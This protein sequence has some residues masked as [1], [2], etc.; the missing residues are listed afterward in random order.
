MSEPS[1]PVENQREPAS[2]ELS[3]VIPCY[4]EEQVLRYTI[5]QLA[6]AFSGAG[7]ALEIVLVDNGSTDRTSVVIEELAMELPRIVPVRVQENIGYGNGILSGMSHATAKWVGMIP[8]DGQVDAE[9]VLRLFESLAVS[10]GRV[11]GKVRRRFRMDGLLRKVVSACYNLLMRGLWPGLGSWDVNG[12]PKIFRRSLLPVLA[13]E[14]QRWFLDPEIMIKANYLGLSVLE[15]NVFA[16]MRG[17]GLS[18]V[19]PVTCLEF[20]SKLL[21]YRLSPKLSGW[22]KKQVLPEAQR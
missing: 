9:D 7:R 8:A 1:E 5:T 13:L 4:N 2:G 11:I 6:S 12:C 10:D 3:L 21:V 22:R 20:L 15:L 19:R 14:S 16:R 17:A 18:H